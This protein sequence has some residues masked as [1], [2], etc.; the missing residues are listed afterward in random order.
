MN[1]IKRIKLGLIFSYSED[2]IAVS[3]YILNIIEGLN[4]L[5]DFEK[6]ELIIFC[7]REE[8]F[9]RVKSI[10]YPYLK[11]IPLIEESVIPRYTNKLSKV[12]FKKSIL[13]KCYKS[14]IVDVLFPG[15]D[16]SCFRNIGKKLY[17][18]GDF[19]DLYFP[20]NFSQKDLFQRKLYRNRIS[21]NKSHIVFS[22]NDS[23]NQYTDN[24]AKNNAEKHVFQFTV[25]HPEFKSLDFEE[26]A[27]LYGIRKRFF[28]TP[29]QFWMHKNHES[30]ISAVKMLNE[31]NIDF[32]FVFTGSERDG[33]GGKY[34]KKLKND[35]INN[36]LTEVVKFLGFIDRRHQLKLMEESIA[37]VQP[38]FFEGWNTTVE[39]G[40]CF[41]YNYQEIRVQAA[42]K[43]KS[44]LNAVIA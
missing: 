35:V 22:S 19:Q 18:A 16:Q 44:I 27:S 42:K 23:L 40:K 11:M 36:Q 4:L 32:Q 33:K 24:F 1:E 8:D 21:Y 43:F 29:N 7:S 38:S 13:G 5:E 34:V 6:P 15:S 39:D 10:G 9:E 3:Y 17:W 41:E 30:I 25:T 37:I 2:Y 26:V 12:I 28:I 14:D 31:K 20:N